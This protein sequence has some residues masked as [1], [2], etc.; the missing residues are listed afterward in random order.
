MLCQRPLRPYAVPAGTI[1]EQ[2]KGEP[3]PCGSK[4]A[5]GS[6]LA[7]VQVHGA[8]EAGRAALGKP[9]RGALDV[10]HRRRGDR[11]RGHDKR[12]TGS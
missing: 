1:T 12:L 9:F 2:R 5:G 6:G 3:S 8:D 4:H 11:G 7:H 10:C